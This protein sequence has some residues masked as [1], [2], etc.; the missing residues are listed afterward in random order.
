MEEDQE[1]VGSYRGVVGEVM[2]RK[3][4]LQPGI[5]RE[6]T[7]YSAE[8]GWYDSDKIRFRKGRPEK[9][10]GWIEKIASASYTIQGVCRSLHNWL[11]LNSDNYLGMGTNARVYIELGGIP[12]SITPSYEYGLSYLTTGIDASGVTVDI[13]D[14]DGEGL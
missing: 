4:S 2:L 13:T 10:G 3:L 8:G 12:Y 5:N 1:R 7:D 11:T 9:I 14:G 6:G